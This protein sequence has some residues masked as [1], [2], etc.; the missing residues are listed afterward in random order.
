MQ[1]LR[2]VNMLDK[3]EMVELITFGW[4]HL[5]SINDLLYLPKLVFY[6]FVVA[7][8]MA[9]LATCA[10]AHKRWDHFRDLETLV[11]ENLHGLPHV[12]SADLDCIQNK[13]LKAMMAC[14]LNHIPMRQIGISEIIEELLVAWSKIAT[15]L[16]LN[17]SETVA[18]CT[19]LRDFVWKELK[20]AAKK[21]LGASNHHRLVISAIK[22]LWS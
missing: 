10:C 4:K 22:R 16:Q 13:E 20:S 17:E 15:I 19:W 2:L 14:G 8:F 12:C 18:G 5:P 3:I 11:N 21:N 6:D 9:S 1:W 7:D